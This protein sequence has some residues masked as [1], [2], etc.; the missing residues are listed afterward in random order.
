M[1][2]IVGCVRLVRD[3]KEESKTNGY[4]LYIIET[5]VKDTHAFTPEFYCAT[6]KKEAYDYLVD[7][8][9]EEAD[10]EEEAKKEIGRILDDNSV[11]E[12]LENMVL[13]FDFEPGCVGIIH[14]KIE[15]CTYKVC[16]GK[17]HCNHFCIFVRLNST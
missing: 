7:L 17:F 15:D 8:V 11:E 10:N 13:E 9:K 4:K 16:K 3:S 5:P 12:F 6:L 2:K 14:I 1:E